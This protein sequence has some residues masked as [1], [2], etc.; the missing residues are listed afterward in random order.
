MAN[1]NK[2][3]HDGY[4]PVEKGYQP[5]KTPS[6]PSPQGGY[7]PTSQQDNPGNSTPPQEE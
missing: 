4:V 7:Q 5:I 6:D 2:T 3:Q 1:P